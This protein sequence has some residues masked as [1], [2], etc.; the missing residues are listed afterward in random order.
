LQNFSGYLGSAIGWY[1]NCAVAARKA[2][3]FYKKY[4]T[5]IAETRSL[6]E[7]E[8]GIDAA[9]GDLFK[10]PVDLVGGTL[11]V[12]DNKCPKRFASLI[13]GQKTA[14][15][16]TR[17]NFACDPFP[18]SGPYELHISAQDDDAEAPCRIRIVVND[19]TVF[20]GPSQFTRFGWSVQKFTIP[21]DC[22]KR[23]NVLVVE[24]ME[25]SEVGSGPPWFMV[26]YAVIKKAV[27]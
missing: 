3:D 12:Y 20:E 2:P 11:I 14:I 15:P 18:P 10:S 24:N 22:L 1:K 9:K 6:A 21:F 13:R 5:D 16:R 7:K 27:Q 19:K 26:N 25:D 8:V 23:G 17:A 4:A